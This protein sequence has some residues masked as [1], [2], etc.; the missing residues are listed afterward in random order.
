MRAVGGECVIDSDLNLVVSQINV[1]QYQP[2]TNCSVCIYLS[3][4]A[5]ATFVV[6]FLNR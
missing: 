3:I 6:D 2:Y 1:N 4:F 5:Y